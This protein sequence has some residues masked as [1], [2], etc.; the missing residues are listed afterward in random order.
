MPFINLIRMTQMAKSLKVHLLENGGEWSQVE[1]SM[2]DW[3]DPIGHS[4]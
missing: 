4:T 3:D 1:S 2:Q